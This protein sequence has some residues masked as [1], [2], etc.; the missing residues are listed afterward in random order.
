VSTGTQ[1]Y[2]TTILVYAAVYAMGA[3]GLAIQYSYAG[4]VNFAYV[5][6]QAAG[7]YT[8][9]VLTLGPASASFGFQNYILGWRLPFPLPILAA[10]VVGALLA[11]LLGTITLRRLRRDYQAMSFLVIS[12]IAT[13]VIENQK[14]I[15]NGQAGLSLI[16]APLEHSL[17]LSLLGYR[18]VYSGYALILAALVFLL[19]RY[20]GRSPLGLAWRA[21]RDQEFAAEALG[22]DPV[23][24]NVSALAFG[25]AIAGLSGAVLVE[26]ITVWSPNSW[27][28]PETF[29]FFTAL[30]VGGMGN[31]WGVIA[32][33]IAVPILF[34]QGPSFLPEVVHAGFI[35]SFEWVIVGVLT[36]LFLWFRP[37]GIVPERP[38]RFARPDTETSAGRLPGLTLRRPVRGRR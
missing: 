26:F 35:D 38:R 29:V 32:G 21:A 15:F 12:I 11:V 27:L 8:A 2:V 22:K 19:V 10:M 14:G 17:H 7:A 28:F 33:V 16:P 30:L 13:D 24:L 3:F 6:L 25:G 37:N 20:V 31:D 1:L 34:L 36:L 9:A 5:V 23:R 18:W 4:I